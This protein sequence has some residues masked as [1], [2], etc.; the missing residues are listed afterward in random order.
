MYEKNERVH[1]QL[2]KALSLSL[3]ACTCM[4]LSY[5]PRKKKNHIFFVDNYRNTFVIRKYKKFNWCFEIEWSASIKSIRQTSGIW[6][7][8]WK[9]YCFNLE[10]CMPHLISLWTR[11][12]SKFFFLYII[13]ELICCVIE[14]NIIILHQ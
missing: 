10:D 13:N 9:T 11:N 8:F 3:S 14:S 4:Q 5:I 2:L 12:I 6:D 7:L 1:M